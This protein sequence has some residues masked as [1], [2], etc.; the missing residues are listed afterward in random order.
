MRL[1]LLFVALGIVFSSSIA[2][3]DDGAQAP[4]TSSASS[5]QPAPEQWY[6][7]QTLTVDAAA[8]TIL[9]AAAAAPSAPLGY[10]GVGGFVLGAPIVDLHLG[11]NQRRLRHCEPRLASVMLFVATRSSAPPYRT[12]CRLDLPGFAAVLCVAWTV[13]GGELGPYRAR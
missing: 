5:T 1:P 13:T 11:P 12:T 4:A 10:A 2:R 9:I 3:A 8:V 7:W 6:G